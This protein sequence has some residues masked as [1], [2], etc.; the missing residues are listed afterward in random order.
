MLWTMLVIAA[1]ILVLA[2]NVLAAA[3]LMLSGR[4]SREEEAAGLRTHLR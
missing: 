1:E 3:A 4:I 2:T